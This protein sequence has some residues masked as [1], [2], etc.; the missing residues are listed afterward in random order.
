MN[1]KI[2]YFDY[3]AVFVLITILVS[4]YS[5]HLT[6]GKEYTAFLAVNWQLLIKTLVGCFC[7]ILDNLQASPAARFIFHGLYL[8]L[9]PLSSLFYTY[10]IMILIDSWY[11]V[12]LQKLKYSLLFLP[13]LTIIISVI[14][15]IFT[16]ATKMPT[17]SFNP[18]TIK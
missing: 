11:K 7:I 2:V 13:M 14:I 4:Q 5:R 6:H 9:H 3:C 8:I 17:F 18:F 16:N 1:M 12:Y 10:Y 15:N